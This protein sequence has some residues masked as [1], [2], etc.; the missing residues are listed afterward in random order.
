MLRIAAIAD[1]HYAAGPLE[2][3]GARRTAIADVLLARVVRRLNRFIKPDITVFLG[4]IL[5]NGD[6]ERAQEEHERLLAV[7]AKLESP[8][9]I[10]P[11][12][13][14]GDV[15]RFLG[16]YHSASPSDPT[17]TLP[18]LGRG[19]AYDINGVRLVTFID[20]EEP[21]FSARRTAA[22]IERMGAA[23]VGFDGP[24]VSIQHV[25][26]F[27]PGASAS[28]YG[29]TNATEVWDAFERNDYTLAISGHWHK[30]DDL[31]SR[32]AGKALIVP[33]LCESPFAFSEITIDGDKVETKRHE[34]R[35]PDEVELVDYHVH[36]PLAYCSDNMDV[37]L[38][39]AL[40]KEFNLAGLAFT[41]HSGQLHFERA[42]FWTGN[43]TRDGLAGQEGR[44]ER[45]AEYLDL[46]RPLQP[47]FYTGLELDAEDCGRPIVQQEVWD[48]IGI[49]VGSI[50]WLDAVKGKA[51][52]EVDLNAA[53]D[54][55]L[56]RLERFAGSGIQVLAH[57]LRI[58]RKWP[59]EDL[60]KQLLPGIMALLREHGV[61]AEVNFHNQLTSPEFIRL[62]LDYGVKF[63]F[64][65]D[66]HNQSEVGDFHPHLDLMEASGIGYGDL[67]DV[68]ADLRPGGLK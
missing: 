68:M 59:E 45:M 51:D 27:P 36:T 3:C 34:L 24:I 35:L 61:A 2:A 48:E 66:S 33:G 49:K 23:R 10:I 55:M 16:M 50:H 38:S 62:C 18:T 47:P 9:I 58:F 13:H 41:E 65:S 5:D 4:D 6:G 14:D 30:G 7:L 67:P 21:G 39:M 17:P 22:D 11:G 43:F 25:P 52:D 26:L 1:L 28:P 12:N 60:P 32:G 63:V 37:P 57:P 64:G 42:L 19:K 8:Y 46:V 29:Y 40:A 20:P 54:E 53:A 31:I 15:E 44:Q 56:A